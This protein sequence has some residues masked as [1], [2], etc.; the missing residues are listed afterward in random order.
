[1][2]ENDPGIRTDRLRL[3]FTRRSFT[4]MALVLLLSVWG[5]SLHVLD[6]EATMVKSMSENHAILY[7]RALREFR[8]L[9]TSEVV[10]RAR[11]TGATVTHD[12][13]S[14]PGAIP[15]PVNL[16]L[17][18]GN[19]M[20]QD[21]GTS[22]RLYSD[23]PFPW[24]E[25][26]G[27]VRD[28]F[29]RR[30]LELLRNQPEQSVSEVVTINDR[31]FLR[32]AIADRMRPSCV[33][34]HNTH[35][36]SP[37]TDWKTGDVRGVLEVMLPL[38]SNATEARESLRTFVP[39]AATIVLFGLTAL[40]L[41]SFRLRKEALA[42]DQLAAATAK[43]NQN[44]QREISERERAEADRRDME[45]Q[46]RHTQKLEGLG[47]LAGGIAHDFNNLLMGVLGHA[48][49][50]R[51][52]LKSSPQA[53]QSIEE[54]EKAV[55]RARDLTGQLLAYAG[56]G[57]FQRRA[58]DLSAFIQDITPLLAT[59]RGQGTR[60]RNELAPE[61]PAIEVDPAQLQ[62]VLLNLVTNAIDASNS[63]GD[64][65]IRTGLIFADSDYLSGCSVGQQLPEGDYVF[66][67]VVDNGVGIPSE[68]LDRIFDPFFTTKSEGRGLGLAALQGIVHGHD[69][70]LEVR[71]SPGEMTVF[72]VLFPPTSKAPAPSPPT[73]PRPDTPPE[74]RI[75][76]VVDDDDEVRNI[77]TSLLSRVGSTVVQASSGEEALQL[78]ATGE[79][80]FDAIV[81]DLRMP[82]IGGAE[83]C[84][85]IRKLNAEVFI[86]LASGYGVEDDVEELV[87]DPKTRFLQKPFGLSQLLKELSSF[88]NELG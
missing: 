15:L 54:I 85:A 7:T 62:Q 44:L 68:A 49:I 52:G 79:H 40:A 73:R 42:A 75:I 64:V 20:S 26:D 45:A 6:L 11:T 55:M 71:S 5:T 86:L 87:R 57:S 1:M 53:E 59:T 13:M 80:S 66:L 28:S 12:Y 78:L 38:D 18:I 61:L 60:L 32:Y 16:T 56:K 23:Y 47:L 9:Y 17:L 46:V 33:T 70:A 10:E 30:A 22:T 31:S 63:K 37:K 88:T 84:R 4:L 39:L 21:G 82:G 27:G 19:R 67:E 14:Q 2:T 83:T 8:T 58:I 76:L 69:G 41:F 29:E 81:M 48:S 24:R 50:A 36:E 35:P 77:T 51:D 34:C 3:L 43:M 74:E 65:W 25:E 72:R